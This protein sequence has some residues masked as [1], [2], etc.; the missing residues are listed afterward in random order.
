V[1]RGDQ[2]VVA[3]DGEDTDSGRQS[4][5]D[6]SAAGEQ[7]QHAGAGHEFGGQAIEH[8]RDDRR[9]GVA[10][11]LEKGARR[12]VTAT[13]D[14]IRR[15][16]PGDTPPPL[17]RCSAP[18]IYGDA[19]RACE[20]GEFGTIL[21]DQLTVGA[22]QKIRPCRAGWRPPMPRAGSRTGW[23]AGRKERSAR[24]RLGADMTFG[25]VDDVG[26]AGAVQAATT[27]PWTRRT[28]RSMRRGFA[29]CS[30]DAGNGRSR[31][32]RDAK[33]R[34]GGDFPVR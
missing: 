14:N 15:A 2:R 29:A 8:R 7:F 17:G 33:R 28:A 4:E 5:A 27:P 21:G 22:E 26:A 16:D 9:F 10:R 24:I 18:R 34:S 25:Q 1:A 32:R 20:I 6:R 23:T 11:S 3:L 12:G 31:S 30:D 13:P 19:V